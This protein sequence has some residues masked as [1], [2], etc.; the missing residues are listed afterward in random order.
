MLSLD[1]RPIDLLH[2]WRFT[3]FNL[4]LDT[5]SPDVYRIIYLR[6]SEIYKRFLPYFQKSK[7]LLQCSGI[8]IEVISFRL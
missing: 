4:F 7:I 5:R 6:G 2:I 1:Q 3:N 8:Q